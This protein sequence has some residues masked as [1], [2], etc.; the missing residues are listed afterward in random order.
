MRHAKRRRGIRF[1]WF[2]V[3]LCAICIYFAYVVFNQQF[4]LNELNRDLTQVEERLAAA[5]QENAALK[6]EKDNLSEAEYIEKTA[7]EELG[8]TKEGELPYIVKRP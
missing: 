8:M 3:V 4:S 6:A 2:A 1:D 5:Q 7:R